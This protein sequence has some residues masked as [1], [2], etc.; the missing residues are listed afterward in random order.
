MIT[1]KQVPCRC[2]GQLFAITGRRDAEG[3]WIPGGWDALKD[4]WELVHPQMT[5]WL[6]AK[7]GHVPMTTPL[8]DYEQSR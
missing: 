8:E 3:F 1:V 5:S 2:C 7:L 6:Y 4:H